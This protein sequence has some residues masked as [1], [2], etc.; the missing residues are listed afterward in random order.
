MRDLDS[1]PHFSNSVSLRPRPVALEKAQKGSQLK[2]ALET[3]P[4][5]SLFILNGAGT[6]GPLRGPLRGPIFSWMALEGVLS[7][8][9]LALGH[10]KPEVLKFIPLSFC[11]VSPC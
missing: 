2:R 4:I 11:G 9:L 10:R 8:R 1:T 6:R 3:E 7:L 5:C